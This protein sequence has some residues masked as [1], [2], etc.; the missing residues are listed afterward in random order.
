MAPILIK[1]ENRAYSP[2]GFALGSRLLDVESCSMRV[3][4]IYDNETP[5]NVNIND[6]KINNLKQKGKGSLAFS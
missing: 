2:S 1:I 5:V 4:A 6:F 3:P